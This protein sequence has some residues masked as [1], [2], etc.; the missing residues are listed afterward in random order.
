MCDM[1]HIF[2]CQMTGARMW[3]NAFIYESLSRFGAGNSYVWGKPMCYLN[4]TSVWHPTLC[5]LMQATC[6]YVWHVSFMCVTW[7]IHTC[8]MTHLFARHVACICA[9]WLIYIYDTTHLYVWQVSGGGFLTHV[10]CHSR[11]T[12]VIYIYISIY[13]L[14]TKKRYYSPNILL[15]NN[16]HQICYAH[17]QHTTNI[18][19]TSNTRHRNYAPTTHITCKKYTYILLTKKIY[20]SPNT[21]KY[22]IYDSPATHDTEITHQQPT[23]NI[24]HTNKP[25]QIYYSPTGGTPVKFRTLQQHTSKMK[26]TS[27]IIS[28]CCSVLHCVAVCCSVLQSLLT[29]NEVDVCCRQCVADSSHFSRRSPVGT[30]GCCSALQRNHTSIEVD[31]WHLQVSGGL[32]R[33]QRSLLTS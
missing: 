15:T 4:H 23:S 27:C 31:I 11:T 10:P 20:Y 14:L 16:P 12:H 18:L 7:L 25:C 29:S 21:I 13:I 2:M 30:S 3:L 1:T 22:Q 33:Q 32:R 19:L 26:L 5:H 17:Q 8:G 6:T 28:V 9:T 24:W